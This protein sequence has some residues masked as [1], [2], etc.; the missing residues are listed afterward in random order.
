MGNKKYVEIL[1]TL[2]TK[3]IQFSLMLDRLNIYL[4]IGLSIS[5]MASL[6]FAIA[7]SIW[8]LINRGW[9]RNRD[10]GIR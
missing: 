2:I 4:V 3:L 5:L 10:F 9:R 8:N 6:K 1:V 7:F